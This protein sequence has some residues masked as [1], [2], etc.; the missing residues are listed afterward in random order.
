[1]NFI[2]GDDFTS[3]MKSLKETVQMILSMSTFSLSWR[4]LEK[5]NKVCSFPGILVELKGFASNQN[6]VIS[7]DLQ[8]TLCQSSY[9][10]YERETIFNFKEN[11][12]VSTSKD[13]STTVYPCCNISCA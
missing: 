8:C 7:A 11:Q 2:K 9:C 6:P 1:M 5:G 13:D 12:E 3:Q 10:S 4:V